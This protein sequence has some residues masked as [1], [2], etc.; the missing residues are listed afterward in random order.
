MRSRSTARMPRLS[1]RSFLGMAAGAS[2]LGPLRAAVKPV[3]VTDVDLFRI[4]IP[5]SAAEAAAGMMH[6]YEVV[7]VSTD[8]GVAGYSFA[9]P[10]AHMLG[11]VK[12]VLA[13]KDLF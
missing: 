4:E 12:E 7:K 8:A 3:R 11:A 1:R 2:A 5:V 9:G 10:G 13:G 6:S